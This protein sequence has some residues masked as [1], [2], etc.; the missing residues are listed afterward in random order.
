MKLF[1][2]F[3]LMSMSTLFTSCTETEITQTGDDYSIVHLGD[4]LPSFS[5]TASDGSVY[6]NRSLR[7]TVSIIIFFNTFCSDCRQELPQVNQLYQIYQHTPLVRL[8][9]VSREETASDISSY[10][11]T[12]GLVIPY[13]PQSDRSVYSLFASQGIPRIYIT[14]RQGYVRFLSSDTKMPDTI[15]LSSH[16]HNLLP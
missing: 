6:S 2:S 7:G 5:V 11:A 3:F 15:E 8:I 1:L 13:S 12:H 10:W 9:A 14:D 16:I 4:S